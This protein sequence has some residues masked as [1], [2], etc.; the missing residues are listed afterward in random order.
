MSCWN[1]IKRI[2]CTETYVEV[3]EEYEPGP[4]STYIIN[5]KKLMNDKLPQID[6]NEE[7]TWSLK[8]DHSNSKYI[9]RFN[10]YLKNL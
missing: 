5:E 7:S 2:F 10:S 3:E 9:R 8:K 4:I 1:C 6:E